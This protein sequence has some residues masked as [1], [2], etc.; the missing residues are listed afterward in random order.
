[1]ALVLMFLT[2]SILNQTPFIKDLSANRSTESLLEANAL[3]L[4]KK[5]YKIPTP[6]QIHFLLADMILSV[7]GPGF[8]QVERHTSTHLFSID[9]LH[10]KYSNIPPPFSNIALI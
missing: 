3:T 9:R 2:V 5:T 1:M 4:I 8:S 6:D 10:S 7:N